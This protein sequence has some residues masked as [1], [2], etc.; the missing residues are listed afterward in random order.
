[1][2]S[3]AVI[4]AIEQDIADG[5][6]L[7]A[8]KTPTFFVNGRPLPSFGYEQLTQLVSAEVDANY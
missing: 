8:T 3:P 1:M 6:L 2:N 5:Q 7:G 4:K